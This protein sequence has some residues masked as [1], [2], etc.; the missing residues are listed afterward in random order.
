MIGLDY[1]NPFLN[2]FEE[3]QRF[4]TH[5]AIRPFFEAGRRIAYGARALDEGGFPIDAAARFSG[6]RAD[7]G[8]RRILSMCRRSRAITP[9]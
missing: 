4:K 7:R 1:K 5:P 2:P 6:R 3:F 8:C 9:R